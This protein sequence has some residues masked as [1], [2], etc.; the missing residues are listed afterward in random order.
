MVMMQ[1]FTKVLH[2][3]NDDLVSPLTTV[4]TTDHPHNLYIAGKMPLKLITLPQKFT[5]YYFNNMGTVT[6]L[7]SQF[8]HD[9]HCLLCTPVLKTVLLI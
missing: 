1:L 7:F 2:K 8:M 4:I 6:K 3:P 5:K 9:L